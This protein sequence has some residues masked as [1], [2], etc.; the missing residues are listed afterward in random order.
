MSHQPETKLGTHLE[1]YL[2]FI[3]WSSFAIIA[4]A[5]KVALDTHFN[6][7]WDL[8]YIPEIYFFSVVSAVLFFNLSL[9]L[10]MVDAIK[11]PSN[12]TGSSL[13][14]IIIAIAFL[15]LVELLAMYAMDSPRILKAYFL[16][17][18][19]ISMLSIFEGGRS[20]IA[21]ILN[22]IF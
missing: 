21:T 8:N 7:T 19:A 1:Q 11:N 14:E 2:G 22:W 13:S 15:I 10:T 18:F 4:F 5:A 6:T 17:D 16:P 20:I 9:I 12:H 3:M